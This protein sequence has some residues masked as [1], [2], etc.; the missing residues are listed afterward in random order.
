MDEVIDYIKSTGLN[1]YVDVYKRQDKNIAFEFIARDDVYEWRKENEEAAA[2]FT[3]YDV[4]GTAQQLRKEL[5]SYGPDMA[6]GIFYDPCNAVNMEGVFDAMAQAEE[7]GETFDWDGA[8]L[9]L[10][11]TSYQRRETA[12]AGVL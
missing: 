2:T 10:L 12:G 6:L 9:C 5:V 7:R 8:S 3:L 4:K 1:Y 11:Y